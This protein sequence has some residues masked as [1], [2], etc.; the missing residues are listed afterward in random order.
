L[1]SVAAFSGAEKRPDCHSPVQKKEPTI[2]ELRLEM[3]ERGMPSRWLKLWVL[4][5]P[6]FEYSEEGNRW[7]VHPFTSPK[8]DQI[9]TMINN[10]P[11]IENPKEYLKHPY[12]AS[13]PMLTIWC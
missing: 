11:V 12:A 8:P 9:D 4:D 13:R 7:F 10:S 5:F 2:S 1:K 3:G 6:L